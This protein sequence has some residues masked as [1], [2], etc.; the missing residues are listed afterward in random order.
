ME[1]GVSSSGLPPSRA[2]DATPGEM[3]GAK[4]PT[5]GETFPGALKRSFPRMNAGALP[6]ASYD[7]RR[8]YRGATAAP[9]KAT[10]RGRSKQRPYEGK[11]TLRSVG[12]GDGFTRRGIL[13]PPKCG[14][15][16]MTPR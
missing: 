12:S 11:G 5:K 6:Y 7:V 2:R 15:L 16:R 9:E 4:A 3:P 13:R 1:C 8:P 14:G 10:A